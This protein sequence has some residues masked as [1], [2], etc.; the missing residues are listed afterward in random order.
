VLSLLLDADLM[1]VLA[2]GTG[3]PLQN[4]LPELWSLLNFLVPPLHSSRFRSSSRRICRCR[5]GFFVVCGV[6]IA[7]EVLHLTPLCLCVR[8]DVPC[9]DHQQHPAVFNSAENFEKWFATPFANLAVG[10]EKDEV[11]AALCALLD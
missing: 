1:D 8:M 11:R 5:A 2:N 3:T 9:N 4:D 10:G 6:L 7:A